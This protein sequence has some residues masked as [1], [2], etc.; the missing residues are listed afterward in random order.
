MMVL[1]WISWKFHKL[2]LF[3]MMNLSSLLLPYLAHIDRP[4]HPSQ[5]SL[6]HSEA[7]SPLAH[8]QDRHMKSD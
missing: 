7:H 4:V 5:D 6:C 1:P 3:T 8:S 2:K